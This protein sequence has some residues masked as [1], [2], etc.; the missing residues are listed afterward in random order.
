MIVVPEECVL[1]ASLSMVADRL[2]SIAYTPSVDP[3]DGPI[4][5]TRPWRA[6]GH[7]GRLRWRYHEGR[8]AGSGG[9]VEGDRVVSAVPRHVALDGLKQFDSRVR[10]IYRR[11]IHRRVSHRL[12]HDHAHL[13]NTQMELLP[14]VCAVSSIFRSGP[15]ALVH[16]RQADAVD[17]EVQDGTLQ[18]LDDRMGLARRCQQ[19]G[20]THDS[21]HTVLR[22]AHLFDHTQAGPDLPTALPL[23]RTLGD[24]CPEVREELCIVER[25]RAT[26]AARSQRGG[27]DGSAGGRTSSARVATRGS[28]AQCRTDAAWRAKSAD[29]SLR[30]PPAHRL[31]GLQVANLVV[32]QVVRR[33][34][35]GHNALQPPRACGSRLFKP[36]VAANES[37][38]PPRRQL[39]Y[40]QAMAPT[41]AVE[42]G[43]PRELKD[44]R[45]FAARRRPV[46]RRAREAELRSPSGL[47]PRP[48]P[49]VSS[50]WTCLI[51]LSPKGLSKQFV[52]RG[53]VTLCI[54]R[55]IASSPAQTHMNI[56]RRWASA[57]SKRRVLN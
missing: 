32:Q 25:L 39:G 7:R 51:L 54:A 34:Q 55:A 11:V 33:R 31:A 15:L 6:S 30:S 5:S 24:D 50:T 44:D 18:S 1:D 9:I 23:A 27:P 49:P 3:V 53:T 47:P 4:S 52:G 14:S 22:R 42:I 26:L 29:S 45:N 8:A 36:G 20:P 57:T 28:P 2:S 13:L 16:D 12:R 35:I 56:Q 37:R 38:V 17:D 43:A 48:Q 21:Q 10:V 46:P 41:D 40:G 19:P